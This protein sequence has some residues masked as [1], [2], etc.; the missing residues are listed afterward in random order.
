EPP[1]PSSGASTIERWRALATWAQH[2][3]PRQR[4]RVKHAEAD[5]AAKQSERDACFATARE[6]AVN[7]G[8]ATDTTSF[9][10]LVPAAAAAV[11]SAR[12]DVDEIDAKMARADVV[13]TRAQHAARATQVANLLGRLLDARN[14][15][16][17][18]V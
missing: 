11:A 5:A 16:R 3:V 9:A 7:V 18:I 12:R 15:E 17:W 2:E 13:R 10:A 8:L 6:H 14:F 1:P 4:Q